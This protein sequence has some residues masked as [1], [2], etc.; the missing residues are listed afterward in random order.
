MQTKPLSL[1]RSEADPDLLRRM[2]AVVV[3]NDMNN[4][5]IRPLRT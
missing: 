1:D 4:R 2:D 5:F 3:Q